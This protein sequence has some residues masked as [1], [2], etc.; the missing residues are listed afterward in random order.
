MPASGT[1]GLVA[2]QLAQAEGVA[3]GVGHGVVVEVR[4]D[5]E[6]LTT[7]LAYPRRPLAEQPVVIRRRVQTPRSMEP[8][9]DEIR[10]HREATRPLRRIDDAERDGPRAQRGE[11]VVGEPRRV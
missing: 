11:R 9:V 7:P 10:G 4:E 5:G 2:D 8:E 1:S 3:R 6:T